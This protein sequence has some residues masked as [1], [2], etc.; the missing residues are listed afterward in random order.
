MKKVNSLLF[1]CIITFGFISC[2]SDED[3]VNLL[4]V[5]ENYEFIRDGESSVDFSGQTTRLNMLSEIKS[6]VSEGDKGN[7]VDAQ[8]LR[9]MFANENNAFSSA[10]LNAADKDL[11]SKTFLSDVE[12]FE[13]LFD[14]L[15]TAADEY[16][17]NQTEAAA[18]VSGRIERGNSGK[19]ILVNEKGWEFTQFIEKGML[20]STFFH[21]IFNVYLSESRIGNDVDNETVEEGDNY[22]AME[23]HWDEAF[24]YWGVPVDFPAELPAESKR[25]WATYTYG[26]STLTGSLD[27]LKDAFLAGR[28]AIVNKDYDIKD[29]S[30]DIIIDEFEIVSA[31]TAVHYINSAL[32]DLNNGDQGNLF[33]HVSEAYMF[34]RALKFSPVKK[35]SD[36]DIDTILNSDFGTSG[37]FWQ[38]SQSGLVD[39]KDRIIASYPSLADIADQL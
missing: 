23:H 12:Y 31:A 38:L 28:T 9:D 37:D 10:D 6:Y 22:T 2:E 32:E 21:Q 18:G 36:S 8:K 34:V 4:D 20:G 3:D 24:G 15:E 29:Q 17:T 16:V 25:F 7:A 11:K 30:R 33:H 27:I 26:R 39:A 5:P 35:I 1:L 19:F 13:N 14:E